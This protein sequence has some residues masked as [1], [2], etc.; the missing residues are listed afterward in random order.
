M[1]FLG[2]SLIRMMAGD[3]ITG[4]ERH[5]SSPNA[6]RNHARLQPESATEAGYNI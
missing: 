4:R 1:K 5:M 2:V 3:N 6:A